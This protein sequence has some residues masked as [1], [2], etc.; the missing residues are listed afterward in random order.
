MTLI[1]I[2]STDADLVRQTLLACCGS[3]RWA[4]AMLAARPYAGIDQLF[5]EADRLWWSLDDSAWL[6]AF[7]KHP[8]IGERNNLSASSA[9]EQRGMADASVLTSRRLKEKN[10]EYQEHFGWIFLICASGKSADEMLAALEAR[11]RADSDSE[12]RTAAGEQA[13]ITRLRLQKLLSI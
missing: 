13:K 3:A 2:N 4:D 8:K 10:I 6:D 12:L 7:A 5:N 1:E 11:L 9:E